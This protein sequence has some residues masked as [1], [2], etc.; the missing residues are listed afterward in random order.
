MA[1]VTSGKVNTNM[2]LIWCV[3]DGKDIYDNFE[4]KEDEMY[5]IDYIMEQIKLYCEPICNFCAARYK[6]RQVFQRENEMVNTFYY[7]IQKCCVQCQ[8]SD[9]TE[10]LID[11]IIYGTK[12][13][14]TSG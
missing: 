2:F 3:P 4:L 11:A 6:F 10:H 1:H 13:Q 14:E 12:V 7:H 5:D 8:F 9:D